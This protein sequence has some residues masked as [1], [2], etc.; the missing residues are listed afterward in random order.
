MQINRLHSES[1]ERYGKVLV[2]A[3]RKPGMVWGGVGYSIPK[4][5]NGMGRCLLWHSE[6]SERY[7]KVLVMAFRKPGTVWEGVSYGIP[8][9]RNGMGRC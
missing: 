6:N 7:G 2:M 9:T 3:F 4:T 8:K 5:R 1:P